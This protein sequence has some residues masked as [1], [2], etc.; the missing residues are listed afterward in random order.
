MARKLVA[1]EEELVSKLMTFASHE[2]KTF[3]SFINGIFEDVIKIYEQKLTLDEIAEFYELMKTQRASGDILIPLDSLM[4]LVEQLP[5]NEQERIEEQWYAWGQWYGAYLSSKF[6]TFER[7]LSLSRGE[8][9]EVEI[10]QGGTVKVRC[11]ASHVPLQY[12]RLLQSYL[13]G[14]IH[15]FGY[16]TIKREYLK[17]LII[18]EFKLKELS[19]EVSEEKAEV[20]Q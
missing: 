10:I 14:V 2:G 11:V 17:G 3:Y 15:S 16:E 19:E 6:Y 8:L 13:E 20:S 4:Y 1:A 12:T 5:A 9:S 18:L 7:L